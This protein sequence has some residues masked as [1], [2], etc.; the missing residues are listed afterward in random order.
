MKFLYLS[1]DNQPNVTL[2]NA[3]WPKNVSG[4]T[5]CRGEQRLTG[6]NI[7]VV[8]AEFSTLSL[9]VLLL[10]STSL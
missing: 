2:P 1:Y 4:Y 10:S 8:W 7:K 5:A 9:A 3:K 6:D